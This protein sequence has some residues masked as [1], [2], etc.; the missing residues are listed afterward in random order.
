MTTNYVVAEQ[1]SKSFGR[2]QVLNQIDLTL[3]SGMIYGL[4]GPSGAGKTTL[5][6]SIL[7]MEAVDSG[8]V[9]VMG[10]RMPNRAVMAQVGYMAQSDALYETLTARENLKF[11]GQLMSVP[12]QKLV[13]MIDYAAGLVD[14][15]SQLDQRVSG[16][17]GGMKRRLSLAIALIQDPRLLILDEPTV[18]IDPEL[19]QQIWA[20]LNKLKATGKS[21]LV[22][23]H[24]MDEAER[25]DYLMLI[26]GGIALAQGTPHDLKQ[27]YD[28][29][30]IEQVFLKAGRMQDANNG[31]R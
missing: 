10:T 5:I 9:D 7:G 13:Q 3:P 4:I 14:L 30:T 11:F 28:V 15:T 20:E 1:V 26:R 18:G 25:C 27:Q 21:M 17:S 6:K 29:A 31:N 24:V 16:Y 22:T 2:Q 19:R 23:T 8:T 12:K